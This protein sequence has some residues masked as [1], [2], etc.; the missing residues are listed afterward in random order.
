[1][2]FF[3]L[4]L[5]F[6][7]FSA[8]FLCAIHCMGLPFVLS[9][10]LIGGSSWLLDET[11]ELA[12]I[13]ASVGIATFALGKSY[14]K[15]HQQLRPLAWALTG[16]LFLLISRFLEGP[17]EHYLTALGGFTIAYAHYVNWKLSTCVLPAKRVA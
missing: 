13:L 15:E 8:S 2:R 14:L 12:F 1:M 9:L 11:M 7:G 3:G 6:L 17:A 4:N 5:D 16:I 10:G